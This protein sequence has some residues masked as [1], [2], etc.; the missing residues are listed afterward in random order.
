MAATAVAVTEG[1]AEAGAVMVV[2]QAA[3]REVEERE[4]VGA[5]AAL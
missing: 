2:G 1:V 3:A 4:G 5:A